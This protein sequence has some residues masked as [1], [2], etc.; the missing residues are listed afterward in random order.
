MVLTIRTDSRT[1]Q[2]TKLFST[3][4][5]Y[6]VG[7]IDKLSSKEVIRLITSRENIEKKYLFDNVKLVKKKPSVCQ[8]VIA[9][10]KSFLMD[11][12]AAHMYGFNRDLFNE[13]TLIDDIC[14][15][16]PVIYLADIHSE[17]G[18][19]GYMLHRPAAVMNDFHPELRKFRQ[20]RVFL[21]IILP[22]ST[23]KFDRY[24]FKG[25]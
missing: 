18:T 20:K 1:L 16:L 17:Y 21:G 3:L 24:D 5:P 8:F 2:R 19:L 25:E 6:N 14:K 13:T 11:K 9:N 4:A 7:E 10:P 15:N 22:V 23:T 12:E